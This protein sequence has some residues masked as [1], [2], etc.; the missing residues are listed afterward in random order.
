M[1]RAC[2]PPY[3][4]ISPI[5]LAIPAHACDSHAHTF[6]PYANYPLSD[7]RSYTPA[8]HTGADF[9]AHLDQ[10]GF[11]RGV[12]VTGSACGTDNGSIIDA[13]K[14]YPTRLRGVA[15]PDPD[16]T[17]RQL[18][19]MSQIGMRGVRVNLFKRNGQAV[20]KNGVGIEVIEKLAPRLRA[21]GWHVQIWIH[22][23]DLVEMAPRLL[24]LD[25][26]LV[27]DHMGRMSTAL[28]IEDPGFQMLC[29]LIGEGK[30]W[31]KISGADRLTQHG[32]P[33]DD[34]D[35]MAQALI[36][37]NVERLVWGSDWPHI[38]YFEANHVPN[39][40]DLVNVLTRWLPRVQDL[41]RVLVDN[42]AKLY[43][44]N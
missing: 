28:G 22:A 36:S 5:K 24:K 14:R 23:P 20:Y 43:G 30:A 8:E 9:I 35:P 16:V 4:E 11:E 39:D 2:L 26:P 7:E 18:D 21:R 44:W 40:G 17:D 3:S 32:A 10:I 6:G 34:V 29:R 1:T 12:L 25:L 42:P 38:N 37:A 13:L 41:Q 33:Y 15:V 31:T 27:I 19:D